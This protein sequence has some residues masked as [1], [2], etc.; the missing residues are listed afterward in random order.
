MS[1]V[2]A[3][4]GRAEPALHHARRALELAGTEPGVRDF[5]VAYAY[6]AMARAHAVAGDAVEARRWHARAAEAGGAIA[7][8]EDRDIFLGDFHAGPWPAADGA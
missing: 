6:E 7:V 3:V 8:A 1:H 4:L 2:Y 5:D